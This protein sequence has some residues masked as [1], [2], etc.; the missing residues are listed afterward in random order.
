MVVKEKV[1]SA[2]IF[3]VDLDLYISNL[4]DIEVGPQDLDLRFT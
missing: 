4:D 2:L 1:A 3:E